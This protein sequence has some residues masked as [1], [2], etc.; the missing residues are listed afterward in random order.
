MWGSGGACANR[1]RSRRGICTQ[2]NSSNRCTYARLVIDIC[3]QRSARALKL[4]MERIA[5][6]HR[7]SKYGEDPSPHP[8]RC[9]LA[10]PFL[11]NT[12]AITDGRRINLGSRGARTPPL[13]SLPSPLLPSFPQSS[14]SI[15]SRPSMRTILYSGFATVSDSFFIGPC[16]SVTSSSS[17]SSSS[18]NLLF[19]GLAYCTGCL[20]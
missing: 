5:N 19:F 8:R 12:A 15:T 13:S 11:G 9:L 4:L 17:S 1:L 14:S 10:D 3:L 6:D 2:V 18:W 16:T 7:Y 20:G